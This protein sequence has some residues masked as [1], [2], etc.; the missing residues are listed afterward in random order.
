M[1]TAPFAFNFKPLALAIAIGLS[2][3]APQSHAQGVQA[4]VNITDAKVVGGELQLRVAPDASSNLNLDGYGNKNNAGLKMSYQMLSTGA[5]MSAATGSVYK[6]FMAGD[7]MLKGIEGINGAKG[8]FSKVS[9]GFGM[10]TREFFFS[11]YLSRGMG[12]AVLVKDLGTMGNYVAAYDMGYGVRVGTFIEPA[13]MRLTLGGDY[14]R[15]KQGAR[16]ITGSLEAEKFFTGLPFSVALTGESYQ[17]KDALTGSNADFRGILSVKYDLLSGAN[18]GNSADWAKRALATSASHKKTVD[19]YAYQQAKTTSTTPAPVTNTAPV[20]NSDTFTVTAGSAANSFN[21]LANDTDANGDSLTITAVSLPSK[22]AASIVNNQIN[23]VPSATVASGTDTFTYT[24]SDG[25]GGSATGTVNVTINAAAAVNR[26]PI[27]N[28]DA[29]TVAANSS[30]NSFAV[31]AN[32]TDPDGDTLSLSA[33]GTPSAGGTATI[34]AGKISYTPKASYSGSETF[35]YTVSDGKGGSATGNVTVT[36]TAAAAVNRNPVA[37]ADSLTV[38]ANA[39]ATVVNVLA[40]DSDPDGDTLSVTAVST[41][42]HGLVMMVSNNIS[43][44]PTAGYSGADS[45]TYTVSD[46]KGG[47]AVGTVNVTVTAPV[48]PPTANVAPVANADS[49]TVAKDSTNNA[50]DVLANDTDANG[51]TLTIIAINPPQHGTAVVTGGK[52]VYTPTAGY[53]GADNLSY[54]ITDSKGGTAVALVAITV[55]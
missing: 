14:E 50:L 43:Y 28:A 42:A 52:I 11:T 15:G 22:G 37:V 30:A 19:T 27:A 6:V 4:G 18:A 44:T 23:Y 47:T 5:G 13:L 8:K 34:S 20:A 49:F 39:A 38:A 10:E 3:T 9:V 24:I 21:V 25:K 41:A 1:R 29:F 7:T 31:L 17:R 16:Q 45:F 2:L 35:S 40:N 48:A 46:G 36:I 53:T 26:N 54:L 51:D 33:V 12:S 32:D 55:Q